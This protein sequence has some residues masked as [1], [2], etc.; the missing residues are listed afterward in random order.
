MRRL[1]A[2]LAGACALVLAAQAQA[3]TT[4][5]CLVNNPGNPN[6]TWPVPSNWSNAGAVMYALAGG[7]NGSVGTS[8]TGG[9]GGGGGQVVVSSGPL[10]LTPGQIL[11]YQIGQGGGGIAANGSGATFLCSTNVPCAANSGAIVGVSGA[12]SGGGPAGNNYGSHGGAQNTSSPTYIAGNGGNGDAYGAGGGGGAGSLTAQSASG[13]NSTASPSG[14]AGGA[15]GSLG[16][17]GAAGTPSSVAGAGTLGALLANCSPG[18]GDIS[19]PVY[20]GGGGGGG[21]NANNL[22]GKNGAAYGGGGG[23]AFYGGIAGQGQ[24]GILVIEYT[25]VTAGGSTPSHGN[26]STTGVGP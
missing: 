15:A 23:G 13:G 22:D 1:K 17:S 8:G 12:G 20:S 4:T 6:L 14:G 5:V 9:G 18:V 26:L 7:G 3:A 2:L 11:A 16:T 25:P 10:S 24:Q 21:A 19:G